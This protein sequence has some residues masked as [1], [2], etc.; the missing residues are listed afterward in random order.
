[1]PKLSELKYL[2]VKAEFGVW[3]WACIGAMDE[4]ELFDADVKDQRASAQV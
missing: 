4:L 2:Q 3:L 1:M